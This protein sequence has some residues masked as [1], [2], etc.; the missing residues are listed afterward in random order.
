MFGVG[1]F[2]VEIKRVASLRPNIMFG[3]KSQP[4]KKNKTFFLISLSH[5]AFKKMGCK[6]SI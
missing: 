2:F 5:G 6:L 4:P 3:L 1:E